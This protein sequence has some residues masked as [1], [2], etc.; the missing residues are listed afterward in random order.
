MSRSPEELKAEHDKYCDAH[1]DRMFTDFETWLHDFGEDATFRVQFWDREN[2]K[3]HD[4]MLEYRI[5]QTI[6]MPN[7]DVMIG[8]R[9][10]EWDGLY[11][12]LEYHVLSDCNF[13]YV[14]PDKEDE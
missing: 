6:E 8:W 11:N 12:H 13:E 5:W 3:W 2:N 14:V 7:G 4:T 9:P 10:V 1:I